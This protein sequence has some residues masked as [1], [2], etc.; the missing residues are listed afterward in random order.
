MT[1]GGVP[2]YLA[3]ITTG[4]LP[5]GCDGLYVARWYVTRHGK[6]TMQRANRKVRAARKRRR[7]WA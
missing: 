3:D 7:G 5:Y 1:I 6:R 4:P 2:V